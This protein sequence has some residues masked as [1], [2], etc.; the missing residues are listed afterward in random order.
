MAKSQGPATG[1]IS[2]PHHSLNFQEGKT[3]DPASAG[4][5]W[6]W[7]FKALLLLGNSENYSDGVSSRGSR[8]DASLPV[9]EPFH[10]RSEQIRC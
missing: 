4:E 8:V 10:G 5:V 7:S 2:L 1:K 6:L 9:A 3:L